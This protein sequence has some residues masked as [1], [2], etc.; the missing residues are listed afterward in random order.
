[1]DKIKQVVIWGYPLYSHTMSYIHYGWHKAFTSLGYK[2]YWFNDDNYNETMDYNNTLFI[3]EGYVDNKIPLNSSSVY[4]I[5]DCINPSKYLDLGCRLIDIRFNVSSIKDC[6]YWYSLEE[7][8]KNGNVEQLSDVSYYQKLTNT[9]G[10]R[11]EHENPRELNYEALY[12]SWATDLLPEEFDENDINFDREQD[13]I[14]YLGSVGESNGSSIY[15]FAYEATKHNVKFKVNNPW[16]NPVD[17]DINKLHMKKS[18]ICPD[19]RG[20]GDSNKIKLGENG[21]C[22]KSIGYIPCRIFKA[23][24]YGCLGITN[25]KSVY[26]LFDGKVIYSDNEQNLFHFAMKNRNN[27]ELILEQMKIVKEKHTYINRVNDIICIV[28]KKY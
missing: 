21:T 27:K 8:K 4:F 13:T 16:K 11:K 9:S 19:I 23:I 22:H 15:K 12:T 5:H 28:N 25:S 18:V 14:Y 24:S 1:M 10:L 26:D 2:T 3:S 6:N 20:E 7:E 17:F